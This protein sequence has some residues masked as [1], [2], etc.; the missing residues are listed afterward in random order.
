MFRQGKGRAVSQ[1]AYVGT[2][3]ICRFLD[4]ATARHRNLSNFSLV[5]FCILV[6][7]ITKT[8]LIT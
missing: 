4:K 7:C 8:L 6:L 5:K 2:E 1:N 3:E